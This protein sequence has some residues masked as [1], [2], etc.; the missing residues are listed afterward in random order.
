M[1]LDPCIASYLNIRSK[2]IIDLNIRAKTIQF[3]EE[4]KSK[5]LYPKYLLELPCFQKIYLELGSGFLGTIPKEQAS[6]EK[7]GKFNFIKV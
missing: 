1:K 6:I 2:W 7:I 4:N 5:S 3:S